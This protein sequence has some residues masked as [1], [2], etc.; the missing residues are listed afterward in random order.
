[1]KLHCRAL[2][3]MLVVVSSA[4]VSAGAKAQGVAPPPLQIQDVPPETQSG[5]GPGKYVPP[6]PA[7]AGLPTLW[8]IGDS[9][10]RNGSK[11]NNGPDGQWGWGAPLVAY[12]DLTKINVVNRALGGTSSRSFYSGKLWSDLKPLIKK[13]DVVM[14]QFGANDNGDKGA[15][16]GTGDDTEVKGNETVHSFG[17]YLKQFIAETRAQG[18]TPIV[19]SLT[20][21][22]RWSGDGK[23]QGGSGHVE[24]AE[25]VAKETNTL[26]VPLNAIISRTYEKLGKEKVDTLYVPSPKEGLHTGWDGA[27]INAECVV[28]GLKA[29]A[30]DPL[31]RFFSARGRAVSQ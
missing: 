22:K 11:G 19:C 10:V 29:L 16:K 26:F 30:E 13:G 17:W 18:G 15:L 2:S 27:V 6:V 1:M 28:A 4:F 7:K 14:I 3:L 9:T 5:V 24:W 21:R 8:L 20:P 12:F 23:F 25:Q 31:E